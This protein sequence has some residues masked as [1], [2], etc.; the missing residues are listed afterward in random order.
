MPMEKIQ[1]AWNQGEIPTNVELPSPT[2]R[3][4]IVRDMTVAGLGLNKFC[5][6]TLIVAH[7]NKEPITNDVDSKIIKLVE[8][9]KGWSAVEAPSDILV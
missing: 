2:K 8:Q 5:Y 1:W 4:A 9:S 6:A 3:Y 7:K